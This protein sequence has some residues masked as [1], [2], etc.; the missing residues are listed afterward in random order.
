VSTGTNFP[1]KTALH[2]ISF[3]TMLYIGMLG[4][5]QTSFAVN[6]VA[7]PMSQVIFQTTS[8]DGNDIML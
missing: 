6:R 3:I 7:N 4:E 1:G 5:E 8:K 2:Q